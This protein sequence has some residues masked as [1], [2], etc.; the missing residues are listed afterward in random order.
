MKIYLIL[1]FSSVLAQLDCST[2]ILAAKTLQ[3]LVSSSNFQDPLTSYLTSYCSLPSAP[4][5]CLHLGN[6]YIEQFTNSLNSRIINPNFLCSGQGLCNDGMYIQENFNSWAKKILFSAP[7]YQEP[8]R[9]TSYYYFAQ[10]TDL[11]I[12]SNYIEGSSNDCSNGP[13]CRGGVPSSGHIAGTYGD[14]ACDI[15]IS[16]F[17]K[18]LDEIVL[19]KPDFIIWTGSSITS[20][21]SLTKD[22]KISLLKQITTEILNRFDAFLVPV[23]PIFGA[24][25]CFP[26]NQFDFG[27]EFWLT[28]GVADMWSIW[29]GKKGNSLSTNGRYSIKHKNTNLRII[30]INT[31]ACDI[32]NF[33]LF[34]N[35]T[36]PDGNINFLQTEL[37]N[38]ET[39]GER[40]YIIGNIA[41]GS[42]SCLS[43]W[44]KHYSILVE[45]YRNI[46]MGQ[47][48]GNSGTDEFVLNK[49]YY[50]GETTGVQFIAPSLS[51]YKD[52][53][54]S[55]R[56]YQADFLSK[57][58]LNYTQYV[59]D[60]SQTA[61]Q[62]AKSYDFLNYYLVDN[63]LPSTIESLVT[64][65][66]SEEILMMK[67]LL[68]KYSK[69][70]RV[71]VGCS[72]Q[73][74]IDNYCEINNDLQER[75]L[76]CQGVGYSLQEYILSKLYGEWSYLIKS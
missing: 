15:P 46:I 76:E 55:Y 3:Y 53:N 72:G 64:D 36:D 25:D 28:D 34:K 38:A 56:F 54:P 18:A 20:N 50:S 5:Y 26:D 66:K 67:Y 32:N 68:N 8:V 39:Y 31:L 9:S 63:M 6:F 1:L 58:V 73:C 37:Q 75:V 70:S 57:V 13:C 52:V 40:V 51:S 49:G 65:M 61:S 7:P 74:L 14:Y 11:R 44:S 12:D 41:P 30:A 62:F 16:T 42:R 29:L 60:L 33:Y 22:Q 10:I 47:F 45:R 23:Y 71:P 35:V 59:L 17:T 43:D 21:P 27:N 4:T 24:T 19:L 2:C 48:F 69:G